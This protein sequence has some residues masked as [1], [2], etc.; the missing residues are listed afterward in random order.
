MKRSHLITKFIISDLKLHNFFIRL[1]FYTLNQILCFIHPIVHL[2][3]QLSRCLL[4]F[5]PRFLTNLNHTLTF[6][7]NSIFDNQKFLLDAYDLFLQVFYS[8]FK[9]LEV[10]I[11]AAIAFINLTKLSQNILV[12][13]FY[14]LDNFINLILLL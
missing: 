4:I 9:Y 13:I 10:N 1:S 6:I 7:K 14:L 5:L 11:K 2:V 8:L 3:P 12:C